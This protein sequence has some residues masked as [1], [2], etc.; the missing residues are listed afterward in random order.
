MADLDL[1]RLIRLEE[2]IKAAAAVEA[3]GAAAVA[4]TE[5]Y[6]RLRAQVGDL[7]GATDLAGEFE[8][9]FPELEPVEEPG[10]HPRE[11]EKA[12][13]RGGFAAHRAQAQLG[14]LAGWIG[15]IVRSMTLER[16]MEMNA[17][18]TAKLAAKR[19]P[20]FSAD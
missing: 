5:S 18:A 1:D 13:L 9:T 19:P 12:K 3:T 15:G 2:T 7:V 8:A 17:E 11:V 20:G 4:L 16:Q 10:R 14:Q 6:N